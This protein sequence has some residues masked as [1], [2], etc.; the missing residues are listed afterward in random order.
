MEESRDIPNIPLVKFS[1]DPLDYA[2]FIDHLKIHIHDKPHLNGDMRMIQLKMHVGGDAERAISGLGSKGI[3]YATA[4]RTIKEQFRQPSV[5]ARALVNNLTKGEKLC[6]SDREKLR[7]FSID[8]MICMT[9]LKRIEYTADINA[10]KDLRKIVMCLPD[11][12]IE[13]W[14]FFVADIREKSQTLTIHHITKF[15][16]KRVK[17]EF[18]PDFGG[19]IN[20]LCTLRRLSCCRMSSDN[21]ILCSRTIR[22]SKESTTVFFVFKS[23]TLKE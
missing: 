14:K 21:E 19:V 20:V 17:A 4:L 22:A 16:K 7:E 15:L 13:R 18:D 2:D 10:N 1:G 23:R 11:H 12:M 3:M 9:T 8:L 5:I 6:R